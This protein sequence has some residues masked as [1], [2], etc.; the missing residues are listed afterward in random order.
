MA[1]SINAAGLGLSAAQI[2]VTTIVVKPTRS[3]GP[4][5]A[6]VVLRETHHDELTITNHPVEQ[7]AVIS[8]HAFKNPATLILEMAWSN[9]PSVSSFQQ[10]LQNAVT[11]T[12]QGVA[13]LLSGNSVE[14]VRDMYDKLLKLQTSRIP[15]TVQ[16]GKRIYSDMLIKSLSTTTDKAS[17]NS[18][19]VTAELQQVLIVSTRTVQVAAPAINQQQPQVTQPTVN[20]GAQNLIPSTSFIPRN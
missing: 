6:Q 5:S 12:I 20:N 19:M 7:G 1:T 13:A 9:S 14:Q 15:F 17:E 8:D 10:A 3:F 18:L 2:A 16:T 4:F 11:G